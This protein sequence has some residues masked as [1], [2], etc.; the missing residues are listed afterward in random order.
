MILYKCIKWT[1][2]SS[3]SYSCSSAGMV[4]VPSCFHL[5][6]WL[7]TS[8]LPYIYLC[9]CVARKHRQETL[10]ACESQK[11]MRHRLISKGLKA[12]WFPSISPT[13][14]C[15]TSGGANKSSQQAV[16]AYDFRVMICSAMPGELRVGEWVS[17][18]AGVSA[19]YGASRRWWCCVSGASLIAYVK[20]A[21]WCGRVDF[22]GLLLTHS[23][24]IAHKNSGEYPC[25]QNPAGNHSNRCVAVLSQ[26]VSTWTEQE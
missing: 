22:V 3:L 11:E 25:T 16:F 23:C 19:V 7:S 24:V 8:N 14:I 20:C 1:T 15:A 4:A 5:L 2:L 9:V 21:F 26:G 12:E 13:V 18:I 17:P 6:L 10:F